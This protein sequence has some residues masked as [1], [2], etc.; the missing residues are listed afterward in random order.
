M[1]TTNYDR[2]EAAIRYLATHRQRQPE[3]A[4]L[5]AHIGLSQSHLHRLFSRWAGVTPKRFLEFLT[6][7]HAKKLLDN[8]E[9][10]LSAA[11]GSGLT[12]P[13]RLHDHFVT[14]E[15]V[16]PGEYR[17]GG[18]GL[19]I[20]FGI[21]ESP[22]GPVFVAW[23]ERGVC[24]VAFVAVGDASTE[25]EALR[26]TW[27]R[28]SLQGDELMARALARSI[29]SA[30]FEAE[31]R[32][33]TAHVRGTN[34]QLAVWRALLRVPPGQVVTYGRLAEK[35]CSAQAARATA[36]AVGRNPIAFLIPCHRVIRAEGITGNYA[37]GVTRKRCM[38]AW[39]ASRQSTD[40]TNC[41][42]NPITTLPSR[43][44]T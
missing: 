3:L 18:A 27:G 23:T 28:A 37:W 32:P 43:G 1:H 8:S 44:A 34:F 40:G 21:G 29:F 15:A 5:A 13:G 12:G 30:P 38:L 7:Q 36:S 25:K 11:D 9:S 17:S 20:R 4:D 26:R 39:E 10:V 42:R 24:R 35:V 33:L 41:T 16:T 19:T 22:F 2:I 6:V 14:V 31:S